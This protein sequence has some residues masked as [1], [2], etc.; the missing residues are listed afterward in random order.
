MDAEPVT[1]PAGLIARLRRML[2]G[3]SSEA[4]VTRR[5]AGTV[6]VIRVVSAGLADLSQILLARWMGG[7]T[8]A[9]TS[10]SGPGCCCSAA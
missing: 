6:F 1:V 3:G 9:S 10:M 8:T 7:S 5:L 2:T 4:S